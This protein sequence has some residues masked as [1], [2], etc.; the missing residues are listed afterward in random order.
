V[1]LFFWGGTSGA[2]GVLLLIFATSIAVIVF[3][4]RNPSEE[5]RWRR[6]IAPAIATVAL[7]VMVFLALDNIATLLGV[8]PDHVLVRAIPAAY[9]LATLLGVAWGLTLKATRPEVYRS[10]GLGAKSAT[11]SMGLAGS[12]SAL[13]GVA[14]DP[15]GAGRGAHR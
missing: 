10:I 11:A 14:A 2:L 8:A 3:F 1:Q 4:A 6:L 12:T 13:H 5:T 15:A 7:A 9:L